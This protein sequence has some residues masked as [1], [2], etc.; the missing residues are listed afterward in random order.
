MEICISCIAYVSNASV[1]VPSH[2][3]Y[4]WKKLSIAHNRILN[5]L[6]GWRCVSM[7]IVRW[8]FVATNNEFIKKIIEIRGRFGERPFEK[9]K[10]ESTDCGETHTHI[11]IQYTALS[12]TYKQETGKE[13]KAVIAKKY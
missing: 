4:Q 1:C 10:M 13:N 2:V 8:T 12:H 6:I 7:C 11:N 5:E 3:L 9:D